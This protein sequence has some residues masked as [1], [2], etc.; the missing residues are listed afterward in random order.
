MNRY[1]VIDTETTGLDP[2]R[3]NHRIIEIALVEVIDNVVTGKE[4]HT[5]LNPQG[6][7]ST[8]KALQIHQIPDSSLLD[9]PTFSDVFNKII[10]FIGE[11]TLVF[12]NEAFDLKFLDHESL[13]AKQNLR[14]SDKYKSRCLFKETSARFG[15][16]IN[17]DSACSIHR[18]DTSDRTI[19]GALID[20]VLTAKLLIAFDDREIEHL[21]NVPNKNKRRINEKFPIPKAHQGVQLNF[22]KN[23]TCKN[24]GK[25]PQQPKLKP[26]GEY[27]S[28][29]GDYRLQI[30][31]RPNRP[32]S[33]VLSCNICKY[34]SNVISNKAV[35]QETERLSKQFYLIDPSC[36]NTGKEENKRN[37]TPE[38]RRYQKVVKT[39]R[40]KERTFTRL[41]P[42]CENHNHG[43]LDRPDLYWFDSKN[44]K[45]ITINK[46]LPQIV[47]PT[48]DGKHED[49]VE[50]SS[51]TFKCKSCKSKFT[52]PLNAQKGQINHQINYQLFLELVN[53]G[54][55]NRISEKLLL[56]PSV[57][58]S[59]IEFFYKQCIQFDQYQLKN[60]IHKLR[61]K[62]LKVSTDRQH[63]Y[64]NWTQRADTRRTK[65]TN[66]STV[67]NSSKFVFA[68]TL[69]F[70]FTS[71]YES[72]FKEF[73]RIGE[74]KKEPYKRRYQQYILPEEGI[75]EDE[76]LKPP[77]KHLLLHQTYSS[78]SH[79]EIIK[80]YFNDIGN[81]TIYADN[82]T[83]FE[84]AITRTYVELIQSGRL[85]AILIRNHDNNNDIDD[86][87]THYRWFEQ[88][89]PVV[90][91]KNI[92]VKFLTSTD[93]S[94]IDMAS[95]HG[96]DNYFQM[97]RRRINMME[98]P[99]KTASKSEKKTV[100]SLWS[101]YASYNPKHL[102][103]LIEIFRVYNNYVLTDEKNNI[104]H[105]Y[106][107]KALSPAQK[108]GLVDNAFT[109][110]DLIE[111]TPAKAYLSKINQAPA[112]IYDKELV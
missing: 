70:D 35:F 54:I 39:V 36:P 40:G 80:K 34:V 26:N 102:S 24:Y 50:L 14:F 95:L 90:R 73:I 21:K 7:K 64:T 25:P 112:L 27:T 46:N 109:I 37:G 52:A 108:L 23:P 17:L 51:Q 31:R 92:D 84:M 66:I 63:F 58:Y 65:I 6:R 43:I 91:N 33:L 2:Y 85:N 20:S 103:M 67:D 12:Y 60:N 56:N 106:N 86:I 93:G 45:S 16:K 110:Y 41:K 15:R 68:S 47:H 72:L 82:D 49:Q 100:D 9:K 57:I 19:H 44:H 89:Q 29:G 107:R 10:A 30:K 96:V 55:I 42:A 81:V 69:N 11:A 101:G 5:Y 38:G 88:A 97:L 111:F 62:H 18:V 94:L 1:V 22:C 59:R 53:K 77:S 71:N 76:N 104:K 98:R 105:G 8:K 4:Y 75:F 83:G 74:Y 99:I 78:L 61:D 48:N 87:L 32:S 79:F 3:G 13:L 28:I